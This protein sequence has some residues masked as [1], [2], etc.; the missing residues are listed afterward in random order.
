MQGN[1]FDKLT[2]RLKKEYSDLENAFRDQ[3]R[4]KEGTWECFWRVVNQTRSAFFQLRIENLP[5]FPHEAPIV[6]I[7]VSENHSGLC[8]N[9]F[10]RVPFKQYLPSVSLLK[11]AQYLIKRLERVRFNPEIISLGI[12]INA[13]EVVLLSPRSL[14][15][16]EM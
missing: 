15:Q 7:K 10:I 5:E 6:S 4:A 9:K 11:V 2:T 14:R 3:F 16:A 12:E 1:Y 13:L 8:H